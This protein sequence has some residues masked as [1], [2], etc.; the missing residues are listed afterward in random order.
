MVWL[1]LCFI[2]N[3]VH[4][5]TNHKANEEDK[6]FY[7]DHK[8]LRSLGSYQVEIHGNTNIDTPNW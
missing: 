4:H 5:G 2:K 8:V 6:T 3:F 7:L 1:N